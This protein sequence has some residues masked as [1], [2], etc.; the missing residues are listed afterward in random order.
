MENYKN[1]YRRNGLQSDI[2]SFCKTLE[3]WQALFEPE[4]NV[5]RIY[6]A[7]LV[8]HTILTPYQGNERQFDTTIAA[9]TLNYCPVCGKKIKEI[10]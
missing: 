2:C 7:H 6:K 5:K 9:F 10:E 8:Q 4:R 1:A 3:D